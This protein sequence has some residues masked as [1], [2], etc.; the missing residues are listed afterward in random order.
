[1]PALFANLPQ[2][3]AETGVAD[4]NGQVSWDF[5]HALATFH[6][7]SQVDKFWVQYGGPDQWEICKIDLGEFLVFLGYSH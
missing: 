4:A 7:Q 3:L 6:G 5:A 2:T 1:L